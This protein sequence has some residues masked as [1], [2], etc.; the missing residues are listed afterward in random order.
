MSLEKEVKQLKEEIELI[1]ERNRRV[2]GDKTWETSYTRNIFI[3]IVT[4]LLAYVL[5]LL[6]GE[7]SPFPKAVIGSV[8]Y[9]LSTSTYGILK[10]WWLQKQ[11]RN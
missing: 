7:S 8:L 4:F 11:K 3:A 10:K 2:E 5:M 9:L 6:I 1:K